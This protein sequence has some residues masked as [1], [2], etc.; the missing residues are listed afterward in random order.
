MAPKDLKSMYMGRN[1][2]VHENACMK[3]SGVQF[4]VL[5][6]RINFCLNS[7]SICFFRYLHRTRPLARPG[8]GDVPEDKTQS[9]SPQTAWSTLQM[10]S[11]TLDECIM[12]PMVLPGSHGLGGGD[13]GEDTEQ[14]AASWPR[15]LAAHTCPCWSAPWP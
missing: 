7:I 3:K 15:A 9:L 10:V 11:P 2:K 5:S 1:Q 13:P 12:Q 4:K 14:E 6:L 8:P